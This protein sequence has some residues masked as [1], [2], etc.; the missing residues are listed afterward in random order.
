MMEHLYDS[1]LFTELGELM[2]HDVTFYED[3]PKQ[4]FLSDE[5]PDHIKRENGSSSLMSSHGKWMI[6][7]FVMK[8]SLQ[9][10]Y[11]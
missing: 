1:G 3:L 11:C 4:H 7:I 5:G 2:A 6:Y 8:V 9:Y 10:D